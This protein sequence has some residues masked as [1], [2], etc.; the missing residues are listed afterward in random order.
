[1]A[2]VANQAKAAR[3]AVQASTNQPR[4]DGGGT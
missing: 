4:A 3:S 2:A 1:M